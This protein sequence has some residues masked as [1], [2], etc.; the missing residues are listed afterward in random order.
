M[1]DDHELQ[2]VRERGLLERREVHGLERGGR[3]GRGREG[4]GGQGHGRTRGH[5]QADH[6]DDWAP[7]HCAPPPVAGFAKITTAFAGSR[8]CAATRR[9]PCAVTGTSRT[10]PPCISA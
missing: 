10:K 1:L 3:W 4:L 2:S 8:Y 5:E 9:T 6:G 7:G